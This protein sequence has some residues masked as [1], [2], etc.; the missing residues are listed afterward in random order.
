MRHWCVVLRRTGCF[1]CSGKDWNYGERCWDNTP[2]HLLWRHI[3]PYTDSDLCLGVFRTREK[4]EESRCEYIRS[5]AAGEIEDRWAEQS[6]HTVHLE[7]DV[8]IMSDLACHD[9]STDQDQIF[10]VSDIEDAMGQQQRCFAA[11]CGSEASAEAVRAQLNDEPHGL[12]F[13][14]D[15][16][17]VHLER[18]ALQPESHND[19]FKVWIPEEWKE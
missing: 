1:A 10:L 4:A 7:S 12:P 5:I 13:Y 14:I 19:R 17:P 9:I 16:E 15:I 11:I 3:S 6:Y 2:M 18:L 8:Q